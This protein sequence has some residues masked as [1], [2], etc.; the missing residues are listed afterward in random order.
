[1]N[2]TRLNDMEMITRIVRFRFRP[3]L[4]AAMPAIF[5]LL[6]KRRFPF[7]IAPSLSVYRTAST[8]DTFAAIRPGLAVLIKTVSSANRILPAKILGSA[9]ICT[10]IVPPNVCF[11]MRGTSAHPVSHPRPR[12]RGIPIQDRKSA[13][14][15]MMARICFPVVPIVFKRP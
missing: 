9:L 4:A 6:P 11:I 15:R 10:S 7:F 1:M 3:R 8:G 2:R 12:P 14:L 13:C 5:A